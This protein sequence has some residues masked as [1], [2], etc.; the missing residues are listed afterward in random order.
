MFAVGCVRCCCA[1]L[2]G[3]TP[4]VPLGRNT[5]NLHHYTPFNSYRLFCVAQYFAFQYSAEHEVREWWA[6][7]RCAV[8]AAA[9]CACPHAVVMLPTPVLWLST[10]PAPHLQQRYTHPKHWIPSMLYAKMPPKPEE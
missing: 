3:L 5:H 4:A 1:G 2:P 9:T 10:A 8:A 6:G 7:G